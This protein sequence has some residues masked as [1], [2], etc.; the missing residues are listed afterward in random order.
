[1]HTDVGS[2]AP[3]G[4]ALVSANGAQE[5]LDACVSVH[6]FL[7]RAGRWA[8]NVAA[9][10]LPSTSSSA[11]VIHRHCQLNR[12]SPLLQQNR[13]KLVSVTQRLQELT[14]SALCTLIARAT[15]HF[16]WFTLIYQLSFEF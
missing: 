7:R 8:D 9:R 12:Q 15:L 1:M 11:H 5:R 16:K 13:S 14:T 4:V 6:V 3:K 10:T 2:H